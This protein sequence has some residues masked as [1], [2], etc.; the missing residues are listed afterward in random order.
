MMFLLCHSLWVFAATQAAW[1]AYYQQYF[2]QMAGGATQAQ[3]SSGATG[4][5]SSDK[6]QQTAEGI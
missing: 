5:Q 2:N 6:Q 4:D 1:S 3:A